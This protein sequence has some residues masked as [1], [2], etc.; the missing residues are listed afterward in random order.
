MKEKILA[1]LKSKLTGVSEAYLSGVA[2]L[3]GET[4]TEESQIETTFPDGVIK[5]LKHNSGQLQTEGDRRATEAQKTAVK[6]ALEKLGL[7]EN[8]KPKGQPPTPPKT[9]SDPN[10]LRAMIQE[11][12]SAAINPLQD[13]LNGYEREKTAAQL[14]GK[15]LAKLKEKQIPESYLKGRNLLIESE[16]GIDTLVNSIDADYTGFKQ[17]MA[18]QGVFISIPKTPAAGLKEG[19]ALGQSIADKR[20][21]GSSEGIQ[22]KKII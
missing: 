5:L 19:E 13:K 21:T 11:A 9:P 10:D 12:I 1:F 14:Q 17:E 2:D 22:G 4:I 8:G 16:D 15:V 3:F 20:N 6:N 18:E 7:D